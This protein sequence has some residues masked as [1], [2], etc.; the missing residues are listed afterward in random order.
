MHFGRVEPFVQ[1]GKYVRGLMSELLA[2]CAR[3]ARVHLIDA[4]SDD[5]G[6]ALALGLTALPKATHLGSSYRVRRESNQ[7]LLSGLVK[8]LRSQRT[9]AVLTFFAQD[10]AS[11]EMVYVNA[12]LTKAEQ[13]REIIAFADYWRFPQR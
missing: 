8:A 2:K 5:A 13:A 11:T 1:A 6:L 12:D 3:R 4:L 10:H 7:A 9:R